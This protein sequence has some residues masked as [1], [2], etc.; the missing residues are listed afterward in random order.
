MLLQLSRIMRSD[1]TAN[2]C[3]SPILERV[4]LFDRHALVWLAVAVC[5]CAR[6]KPA[7]TESPKEPEPQRSAPAP[8][9]QQEL[10]SIDLDAVEHLFKKQGD[11][12][13]GCHTAGRTRVPYLA[14]EVTIFLRIDATGH[15]RYGYLEVSALGDRATESCI[16]E[17]LAKINWPAPVGGEAEV[18]HALGW[19]AGGERAPV[20]YDPEKVTKALAAQPAVRARV[21]QCT[22]G[23]RGQI[24]LTGYI[25]PGAPAKDKKDR[26]RST[27]KGK[28]KDGHFRALGA[29]ASTKDAAEK[30][31]CVVSALVGLP[32]PTPGGYAAKVSFTP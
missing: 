27:P 23:I 25:E 13:E 8:V 32:I 29:S 7:V 2:L 26:T 17:T 1:G 20:V 3:G 21:G 12:I 10:G 4:G 16:L 24:A 14:G 15:V 22:K 6:P 31:D 11:A 18:R 9:M 30:I 19:E 5:A 28:G